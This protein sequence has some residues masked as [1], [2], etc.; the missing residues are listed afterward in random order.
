MGTLYQSITP[1]GVI[2]GLGIGSRC[3]LHGQP[4]PARSILRFLAHRL[5]SPAFPHVDG[6]PRRVSA[7]SRVRLCEHERSV[8]KTVGEVVEVPAL[9]VEPVTDLLGSQSGQQ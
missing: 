3:E 5:V 7:T 8:G 9:V 6:L 1:V 4:T 2:M